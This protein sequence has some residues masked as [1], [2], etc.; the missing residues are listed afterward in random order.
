MHC[1]VHMPSELEF[2]VSVQV[3]CEL[4]LSGGRTSYYILF[5]YSLVRFFF[6]K[7]FKAEETEEGRR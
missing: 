3:W 1:L 5:Q 6:P 7:T 2:G 4:L